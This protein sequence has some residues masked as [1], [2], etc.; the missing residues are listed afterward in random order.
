MKAYILHVTKNLTTGHSLL[1][2]CKTA[3]MYNKEFN[4]YIKDCAFVN[5]YY[6]E[7]R[8]PGEN[9]LQVTNEEIEECLNI[10]TEIYEKT[11]ELIKKVK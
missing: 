5:Q 4:K 6:V 2:L 11:V 8:Y 3:S 1:Y 9:N 7:T 10:A